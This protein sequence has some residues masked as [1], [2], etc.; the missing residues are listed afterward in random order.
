MKIKLNLNSFLISDIR[1]Q[2]CCTTSLLVDSIFLYLTPSS[3]NFL[4]FGI[5]IFS[6]YKTIRFFLRTHVMSIQFQMNFL[7]NLQM[8]TTS[9]RNHFIFYIISFLYLN[10]SKVNQNFLVTQKITYILIAPNLP[11]SRLWKK[12]MIFKKKHQ[13]FRE[14]TFFFSL[15]DK[16]Q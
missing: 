14:K 15:N 10:I 7:K 16:S 1:Q 3:I 2:Y 4:F 6:C 5:F 12:K 9:R 8:E 13:N 11:K